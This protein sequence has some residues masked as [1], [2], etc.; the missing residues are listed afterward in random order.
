MLD[1]A[2]FNEIRKRKQQKAAAGGMGIG[3]TKSINK[4]RSELYDEPTI[5]D[6]Y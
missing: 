5:G 3:N 4:L 6:F 2:E 1:D